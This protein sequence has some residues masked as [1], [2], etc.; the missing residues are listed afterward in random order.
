MAG[1]K[2]VARLATT[3]LLAA[4]AV[5]AA[6]AQ[7]VPPAPPV[8]PVRPITD[9]YFGQAVPDPY[10]WMEAEGPDFQA[11]ARGQAD[12]TNAALARIPGRAALLARIHALD[13]VS[14]A[15]RDV[16]TAGGKVF[17]RKA[18]PGDNNARLFVRD[19]L[20][21][22]ERVLL[23]PQA[24]T[25]NGVHFSIDYFAPAPDGKLVAY[26][27]SPGGSENSTLH[28]LRTDGSGEAGEAITRTELAQVS[29]ADDGKS[30]FYTRL[31]A[32]GPADPL[33][34]KY[35]KA[36]VYRHVLGTDAT[37]DAPVFGGSLS[38]SASF[39]LD[40]VPT[41]IV[42][43]DS[44]YAFGVVERGVLNENAVYYAPLNSVAGPQTPWRRLADFTDD[45]VAVNGEGR[46]V[47][48][49]A[50]GDDVYLLTHKD[51]PHYRIIETNL[52]F[53]RLAPRDAFLPEDSQVIRGFGQAKDGLY[54]HS[55][56]GG[57]GRVAHVPFN[58]SPPTIIPNLAGGQVINWFDGTRWLPDSITLPFDGS[59]GVL[60]DPRKD[61]A[62]LEMTSWTQAPRFLAYDARRRTLT[63]TG[64]LPPSSV[65]FSPY[66]SVEVKATSADGTL[67]PLSIVFP[68]N[69]TRDGSHPTLLKGYG[70]YGITLTPEFDATGLAWLERGGVLAFAH[71]RGGG[72]Y[73]EDWHLG[74]Q[75]LTKHHTWEDFLACAQYLIDAK[76]TSP[77]HLAGSGTSAGGITIGRAIT[78]RPDLFGAA[79]IR[80]GSSN[81]LRAETTPNGPPNVP[82]FGTFTDP[83]GF[84]ALYTMDAYSHVTDGTAY[85]AVLVTTGIN[86]PRVSSW[87]PAKM[88]ARLEAATAS[89]KPVLLRVDYDAGHG[90]GS[91]KSQREADEA[92]EW[93][94]LLWQLGDPAFQP[95]PVAGMKAGANKIGV[96]TPI[97]VTGE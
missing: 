68:K 31:Q 13:N 15:V 83:D 40:D 49:A 76:Y 39:K 12:Y 93:S 96:V 63:D 44:S 34:A 94:F 70:S 21:G 28:V 20:R 9:T 33:T 64:L 26:G 51:A 23:D 29:W 18:A 87:E 35:Q 72:E 86:D 2:T 25:R 43:P 71:I 3:L 7:A 14:P 41:V 55:L 65:D 67:V 69:L 16:Q 78:V 42:I 22:A 52:R 1:M 61:G 56:E 37:A 10:R 88:A 50:H 6:H 73:G 95:K 36:L 4:S 47:G 58:P 60:T 97:T 79:L 27:V 38:P 75:K 89:G 19:G 62:L 59:V 30:F 84:K 24:L 92:D 80:V 53:R 45:V 82:E 74:G 91:T 48:L 46:Q 66:T 8:A 57:L 77:A 54:V 81:P 90:I 5:S 85:P 11:W 17:Y 32:T